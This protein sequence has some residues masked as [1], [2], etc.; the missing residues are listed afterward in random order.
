M[1]EG[2]NAKTQES[3]GRAGKWQTTLL[4]GGQYDKRRRVEDTR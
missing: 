1:G 2:N 3:N 4:G